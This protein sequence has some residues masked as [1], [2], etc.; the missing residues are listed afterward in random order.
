MK[1]LFS[2]GYIYV[3]TVDEN[4]LT[5][6]LDEAKDLHS[7]LGHCLKSLEDEDKDIEGAP[8]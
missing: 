5:F 3:I 8:V 4:Y 2:N 6:E 1:V 7:M